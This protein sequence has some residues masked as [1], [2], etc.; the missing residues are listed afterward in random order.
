MVFVV[1]IHKFIQCT[2]K[3]PSLNLVYL[4]LPF[5]TEEI[6]QD[7]SARPRLKLPFVQA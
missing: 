3:F 1:T 6:L 2:E 7:A 5:Y 4:P